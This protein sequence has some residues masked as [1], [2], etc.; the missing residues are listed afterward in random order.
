MTTADHIMVLL[1]CTVTILINKLQFI[2]KGTHF[3]KWPV[4]K[5]M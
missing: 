2:L 4:Y 3:E 5:L 1:F